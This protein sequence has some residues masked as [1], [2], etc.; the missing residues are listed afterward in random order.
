MR[1]ISGKFKGKVII[2]PKNIPTRPTTDFAKTGLFNIL[3]NHFEFEKIRV[4]D[5]FAGTGSITLEFA[6]RG[7]EESISV[8]Q[9]PTCFKYLISKV[10]ELDLPGSKIYR[11]DVFKFIKKD[12][13]VFDIIFADPPYHLKLK[14]ELI[15][16]IFDKELL[17][18]NGW[19]ILEQSENDDIIENEYFVENR[20]Y[21]HVSFSIYK[22]KS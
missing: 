11:A 12:F 14:K 9:N 15:N 18:E 17:K 16:I 21:G 7:C 19:F 10:K 4:L 2:A 6:S 3:R 5:L 22:N 1:I 20:K 13:G 8:E